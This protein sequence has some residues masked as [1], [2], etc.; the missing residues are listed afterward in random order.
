MLNKNS[1]GIEILGHIGTWYVIDRTVR[2]SKEY[3]LLES[4]E[5]GEDAP[6]IIVD[7]VKR[8]IRE[9]VTDGFNEL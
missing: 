4:E 7:S 2:F 3:F 5:Y 9:N 6:C 1:D 8:I